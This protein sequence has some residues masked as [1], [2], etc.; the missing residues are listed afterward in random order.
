MDLKQFAKRGIAKTHFKTKS[1]WVAKLRNKSDE[2][3]LRQHSNIKWFRAECG[4][5][6]AEALEELKL[7]IEIN[8]PEKATPKPKV[9]KLSEPER[10]HWESI[11][12]GKGGKERF[13]ITA[14]KMN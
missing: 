2:I 10:G 6:Y 3:L 9:A 4:N 14:E 12:I 1:E 5:T 7:E 8:R 11:G 13:W